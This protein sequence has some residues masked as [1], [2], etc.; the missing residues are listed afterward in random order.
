MAQTKATK[1]FERN[2][3]KD[4]IKR[5]K[6]F[7]KIKQRHQTNAKKKA[8]RAADN[9]PAS[10]EPETKAPSKDG[11]KD[12]ESMNVDDFFQGGFDVPELPQ[13]ADKS[14]KRK[15]QQ[16]AKKQQE[17]DDESAPEEAQAA[18]AADDA[19][20]ASDS[21][22]DDPEE[23]QAQLDALAEKDP[24][25]HKYMLE[26]DAGHLNYEDADLAEVDELSADEDDERPKKKQKGEGNE[27]NKAMIKKWQTAMTTQHSLRAAKEVVLAFRAAAHVSDEEDKQFKYSIS[28]P[29]AYHGLLV[30]AL[31]H[32]PE[33]LQHHLP[34]K[35]KAHGRV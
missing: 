15:R 20:E 8:K 10:P 3:L 22:A 9:A 29:Q 33:V 1:K 25:F 28:D 30:V 32:L 19:S 34:V 31:K 24:D 16:P 26:N 12:F 18:A 14:L 27:V 7:A 6:E 11:K 35:E 13:K 23:F 21:E 5:R 4:T 17:S 2:H